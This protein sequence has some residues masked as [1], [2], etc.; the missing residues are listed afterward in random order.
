MKQK[1]IHDIKGFEMW[2]QLNKWNVMKGLPLFICIV[3]HSQRLATRYW[4]NFF[5]WCTTKYLKTLRTPHNYMIE[6][7]WACESF[8]L[9]LWWT[10]HVELKMKLIYTKQKKKISINWNQNGAKMNHKQSTFTRHDKAW[11]WEES[12]LSFL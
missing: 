5:I 8:K 7:K 3:M 12:P 1:C 9:G 10:Q 2:N 11:T 4:G 6:T